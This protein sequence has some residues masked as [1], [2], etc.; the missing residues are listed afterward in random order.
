[1]ALSALAPSE[2]PFR[3]LVRARCKRISETNLWSSS[4]ILLSMFVELF[5]IACALSIISLLASI[6]LND[7]EGGLT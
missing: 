7:D 5:A 6:W 2:R 1:L 4:N 3:C